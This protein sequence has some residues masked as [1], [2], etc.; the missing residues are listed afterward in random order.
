MGSFSKFACVR[1]VFVNVFGLGIYEA[2]I[3]L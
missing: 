1:L 2:L 3:D